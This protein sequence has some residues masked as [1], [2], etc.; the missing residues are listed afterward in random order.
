[1][2]LLSWPPSTAIASTTIRTL[3][4]SIKP[5]WN[6]NTTEEEQLEKKKENNTYQKGCNN[7]LLYIVLYC[8]VIF[9]FSR[10][11]HE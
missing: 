8:V 6:A 5:I 2:P 3:T 4:C 7:S 10:K 1:M 11:K 9:I